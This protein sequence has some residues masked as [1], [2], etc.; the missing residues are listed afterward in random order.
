[1]PTSGLYSDI[2]QIGSAGAPAFQSSWR[3]ALNGTQHAGYWVDPTG[4]VRLRGLIQS[5]NVADASTPA[6]TLPSSLRPIQDEVFPAACTA[7]TA[8]AT[9]TVVAAGGLAGAVI[10]TLTAS[11][12]AHYISLCGIAFFPG[13]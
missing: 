12:A 1:M 4:L 6:F 9:V 8:P 11:G 2:V 13:L 3:N 5:S 7:F 10:P